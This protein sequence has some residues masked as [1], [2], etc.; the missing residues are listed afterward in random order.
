MGGVMKP[1]LWGGGGVSHVPSPLQFCKVHISVSV[2]FHGIF[3]YL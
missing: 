1:L 3:L 2:Q